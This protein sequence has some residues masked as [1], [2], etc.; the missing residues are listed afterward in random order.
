LR[1]I[2]ANAEAS[3]CTGTDLAPRVGKMILEAFP[4]LA[5][6]ELPRTY[7]EVASGGAAVHL[8][9]VRYRDDQMAEQTYSVRAF[10]MPMQCAG[11]LFESSSATPPVG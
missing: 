11:V 9:N 3:R 10:P 5:G 1:L 6:T 8:G 7:L 4:S 2:Y